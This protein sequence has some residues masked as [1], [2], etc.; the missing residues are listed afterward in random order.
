MKAS[1]GF[2]CLVSF[3]FFLIAACPT[4][5]VAADS[6][7]WQDV[8]AT[9]SIHNLATNGDIYVA[10]GGAYGNGLWTSS[11]LKSWQRADLPADAGHEISSVAYENGQFIAV[12]DTIVTSGDGVVWAAADVPITLNGEYSAITYGHGMYVVV[13]VDNDTFQAVILTSAD[14]ET[15]VSQK[16]G[17]TIPDGDESLLDGVAW[18]GTRFVAMGTDLSSF[19]DIIIT[20]TDGKNWSQ[21]ALP[22]DGLNGYAFTNS[23]NDVL[24]YGNGI[25]VAGGGRSI[26]NFPE[27]AVYTSSDGVHW[28][29]HVLPDDFGATGI[30][31]VNN[32]FVAPGQTYSAG[33]SLQTGY[34]VSTDGANWTFA[35]V[36][37]AED[38]LSLATFL[39]D[40]G[41]YV[42][43]GEAG[44]WTSTDLRTWTTRLMVGRQSNW[45]QCLAHGDG[46]GYILSGIYSDQVLTSAN[47]RDW[48]NDLTPISAKIAYSGSAHTYSH[49]CM[50]YG[51]SGYVSNNYHSTNGVDW[52]ASTVP[53]NTDILLVSYNGLK[54]L[55][56]A[57]NTT[58]SL[59]D[60]DVLES[61]DGVTWTQIPDNLPNLKPE[62]LQV[63]NG[64]FFLLGQNNNG[65]SLL[66]SADGGTWT[67]VTPTASDFEFPKIGYGD[68]TFI[69]MWPDANNHVQVA[70][71]SDEGAHWTIETDIF[72]QGLS[73]MPV[74]IAYGNGVYVAVGYEP[75]IGNEPQDQTGAYLVS[76]DGLHWTF[77]I[78]K[79][80]GPFNT[81]L[82]DGS[83]F[84]ATGSFDILNSAGG[85]PDVGLNIAATAPASVETGAQ[86]SIKLTVSNDGDVRADNV[87]LDDT[88]PTSAKLGTTT[89]SQG[90]CS[91]DNGTLSCNLGTIK[92]GAKAT[93]TLNFTAGSSDGKVVNKATAH[94]DQPMS[95][96]AQSDSSTTVA[97]RE[98]A[99]TGGDGN[100]IPPSSGGGGGAFGLLGLVGLLG[101]ALR[102][103]LVEK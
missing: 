77:A 70:R 54:Y 78:D 7:Y 39:Y 32:S 41:R 63:I 49:G 44:V 33:G 61:A 58:N 34:L 55:A 96:N 56:V 1:L 5:A 67:D 18:N 35:S 89:T 20:S 93:V 90:K 66:S 37:T 30:Q 28:S 26:V 60:Y 10:G 9:V 8:R 24:A 69:V 99:A 91:N 15:W 92:I 65:F 17:I 21:V 40:G 76:K 75:Q 31:F 74:S 19:G 102:R 59:E 4:P 98:P 52:Q 38:Y 11:D 48:P 103:R 50:A 81:L 86:F 16:T 88:L 22:D 42:I 23:F 64:S 94:A 3:T 29:T 14:G 27:S 46:G 62:S 25:F 6:H 101:A 84:L 80:T 36:D 97:V 95:D 57:T 100:S 82:W 53:P 79:R 72:P 51:P 43:A 2:F 45:M 87:V 47:G 83:K 12:G 71:S 85:I 13:G 68:G 73:F